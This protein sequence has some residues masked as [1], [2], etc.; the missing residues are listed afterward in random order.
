M[1][2]DQGKYKLIIMKAKNI[3]LFLVFIPLM[4]FQGCSSS[5]DD[6]GESEPITSLDGSWQGSMGITIPYGG[7]I[8]ET[9]YSLV[10]FIGDPLK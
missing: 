8:Y 6:N 1:R 4:A 7:E 10:N 9:R 2:R 3:L 5:N